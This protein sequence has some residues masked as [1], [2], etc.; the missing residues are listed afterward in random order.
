MSQVIE[1][2]VPDIG[3][4]SLIPVIELCVK[5][6]DSVEAD[7]SLVTL[8]SEKA[9]MDVPAPQAGIVRELRV[10]LGDHVSEGTVIALLEP[11][12]AEAP[13]AGPPHQGRK[14]RRAAQVEETGA[15]GEVKGRAQ[16]VE[17]TLQD[18]A[19][20]VARRGEKHCERESLSEWV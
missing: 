6:G 1:I 7:A 8:E 18:A 16:R 4:F 15:A 20:E 3:D 13:A 2:K 10:G 12:A 17:Q 19:H 14:H 9:T 11:A 5:V